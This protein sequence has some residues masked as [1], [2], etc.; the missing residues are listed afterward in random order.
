MRFGTQGEKKIGRGPGAATECGEAMHVEVDLLLDKR[1]G[2]ASFSLL[3]LCPPV[4]GTDHRPLCLFP[5]CR[6]R[7]FLFFFFREKREKG[8]ERGKKEAHTRE[9]DQP[10]EKKKGRRNPDRVRGP[11]TQ[12]IGD[13]NGGSLCNSNTKD[14]LC[15]R[16]QRQR[17]SHVPTGPPMRQL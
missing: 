17:V 12:A 13:S 6:R 14:A 11:C 7:P 8:P 15:D 1:R 16:R 4:T 9:R 2:E 10:K 5:R 3:A